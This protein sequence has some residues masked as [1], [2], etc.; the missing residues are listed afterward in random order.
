MVTTQ[1]AGTGLPRPSVHKWHYSVNANKVADCLIA[2]E[3]CEY[4]L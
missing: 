3:F 1:N 2:L 4:F